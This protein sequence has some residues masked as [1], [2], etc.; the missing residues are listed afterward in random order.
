MNG[1]EP[2]IFKEIQARPGYSAAP[3]TG[4]MPANGAIP[5]P[6]LTDEQL[7]EMVQLIRGFAN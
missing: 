6:A 5:T 2:D 1:T 4:A 3:Y 7:A